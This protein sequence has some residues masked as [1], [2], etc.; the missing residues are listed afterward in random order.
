[1]KK[2][3]LAS[4]SPR[5]KELLSRLNIDFQAV[6]AECEEKIKNEEEPL[7][8]AKRLSKEKA[9]SLV[10]KYP[11]HIIIGADTFA[12]LDKEI[13]GKPHTGAEAKR[14][15]NFISGR[16]LLAITGFTVWDT[17]KKR[18]SSKAVST[19]V[20]FKELSFREIDEYIATGEPLDKAGAFAIQGGAE[21]FIKKING[22]YTN[23]IG[24]PLYDLAEEL[25]K[26]EIL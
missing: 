15:L 22:S 19:E 1:M 18:V 7:E 21:V 6:P 4:S 2:V 8:A 16:V 24:L 5:R 14:M 3:L 10:Y 12:V 25:K 11:E 13:L 23:V 9:G 17:S 20:H 26:F